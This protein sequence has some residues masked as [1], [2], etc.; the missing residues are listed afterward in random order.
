MGKREKKPLSTQ[1]KGASALLIIGGLLALSGSN[2]VF[3]G[4]FIVG[5]AVLLFTDKDN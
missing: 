5:G 1:R 2:I 3:A 4:L